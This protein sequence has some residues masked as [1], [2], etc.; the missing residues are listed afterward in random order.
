MPLPLYFGFV[1]ATVVLM[2]I[3]GPKCR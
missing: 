1:T 3:P 2:L